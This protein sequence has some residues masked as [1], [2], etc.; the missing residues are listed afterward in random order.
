MVGYF[1]F[2]RPQFILKPA[3][4]RMELVAQFEKAGQLNQQ[5]LANLQQY[6]AQYN[7]LDKPFMEG[8]TFRKKIVELQAARDDFFNDAHSTGLRAR[9]PRNLDLQLIQ[10]TLEDQVIYHQRIQKSFE[11]YKASAGNKEKTHP[12]IGE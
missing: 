5:L 10:S 11:Q 1:V 8:E 3:R 6:A 4:K 9:H 12:P 7:L 2:Y